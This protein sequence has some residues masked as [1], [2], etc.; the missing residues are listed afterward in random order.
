V[1]IG[2]DPEA[3]ARRFHLSDGGIVVIP[4]GERVLA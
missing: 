2:V 4:K 3:D 1:E